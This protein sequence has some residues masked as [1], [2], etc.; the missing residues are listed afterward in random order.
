MIEKML[1][2]KSNITQYNKIVSINTLENKITLEIT[3]HIRKSK[4]TQTKPRSQTKKS[5]IAK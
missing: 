3:L 2:Q 1:Q 5:Q 4:I